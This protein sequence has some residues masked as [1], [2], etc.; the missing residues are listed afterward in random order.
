MKPVSRAAPEVIGVLN[1]T[2]DSFYAGSRV[3]TMDD[4]LAAAR[5]MLAEGASLLEVGGESS[6]PGSPDVSIDAELSR[7][8]PAV[9]AIRRMFPDCR[10]VVDTWK[11]AVAREALA[12]GAEI[13]NDVTAGRGDPEMFRTVAEA[14][15]GIV[16][17]FSKDPTPRTTV[18]SVTY[19]D[20]IATVR[21]FLAARIAAAVAAGTARERIIIDPGLG[22]FVSSDPFYSYEI[23]ARLRELTDL[24]PVLVSPSRKSFLAGPSGLP[25]SERL[26][27]T[28]AASVLAALRGASFIRTHDTGSVKQALERTRALPH[29]QAKMFATMMTSA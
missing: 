13:I 21:T 29:D 20:V 5:R 7:T 22:H 25:P 1:V 9:T 12:A 26:P 3:Q 2:P 28:V 27:A 14:G 23:L 16:L 6:G 19:D 18:R 10:I 8:V 24:A 17:M 11:A 15:A 4:V